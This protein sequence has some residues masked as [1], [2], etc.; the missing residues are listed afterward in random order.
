MCHTIGR[1]D[2]LSDKPKIIREASFVY[3]GI[4]EKEEEGVGGS[5]ELWGY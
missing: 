4:T 3:I 1:L 2:T 5:L